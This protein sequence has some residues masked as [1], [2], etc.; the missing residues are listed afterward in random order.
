MSIN[1]HKYEHVYDSKKN[2]ACDVVQYIEKKEST[3]Y[4][5][6][7]SSENS[8]GLHCCCC[9]IVIR[10]AQLRL[11][12]YVSYIA[13]CHPGPVDVDSH[14]STRRVRSSSSTA[15]VVPVTE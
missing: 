6:K 1:R 4:R 2:P 14:Y 15:V 5:G 12:G 9:A 7:H 13:A 3:E 10:T 8:S 11:R